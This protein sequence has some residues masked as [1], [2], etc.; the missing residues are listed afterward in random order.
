MGSRSSAAFS[1]VEYLAEVKSPA[2]IIPSLRRPEHEN[3]SHWVLLMN[4]SGLILQHTQ[5]SIIHSFSAI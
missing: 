3:S 2:N 5:G 4:N 1:F